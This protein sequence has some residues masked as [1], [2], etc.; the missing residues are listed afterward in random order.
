MGKTP[1]SIDVD[2]DFPYEA[3]QAFAQ[4]HGVSQM[5][6]RFNA[7][8]GT[9]VKTQTGLLQEKGIAATL[10][11]LNDP[12]RL[13]HDN[14][15]YRQTLRVGAGQQQPGVDLL[16]VW[17]RRNFL[18]CANLIQNSHPGDRVVVFYGSGHAFLLRQCVA[19]TPGFILVEPNRFLPN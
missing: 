18:T 6:E 9:F 7:E 14:A 16:T 12:E 15:F 1:G 4:T 19:E 13:S 5:L 10:R 11:Y 2:G 17:Y 8:I 3:V